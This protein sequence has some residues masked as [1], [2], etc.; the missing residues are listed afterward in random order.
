MDATVAYIGLLI[1][2]VSVIATLAFLLTRW[3]WFR[4]LL[5]N[6]SEFK[7]RL[8][9]VVLFG[10]IGIIGTY[11]GIVVNTGGTNQTAS[12]VVGMSSTEAI[13]NAR[14]L[15]VAIAGIL[16][17]P[18]M[19]L[20]SGLLAGLHR[21]A[22]GG[23]TDL[24]CAL[25]TIWEGLLAGLIA[26]YWFK[27]RQLSVWQVFIIGIMAEI[28]QMLI[29]LAV[30]KPYNMAL[31][32]VKIIGI[33][34][35]LANSIGLAVFFAILRSVTQREQEAVA[36]FAHNALE[37]AHQTLP[38]F[39]HGLTEDSARNTALIIQRM[40]RVTA[41][42]LT[43]TKMI[44]AF[45]GKGAD[46]HIAGTPLKTD[47]THSVIR[48]GKPYVAED[49]KIIGCSHQD[50]PL[51]AAI[52]L[53]LRQ[54]DELIGTL[55]LYFET[56][57]EIT[58]SQ[59]ELMTG[60]ANLFS[61]QLEL[62][63]IEEQQRLLIEAEIKAL[64]AQ[65]NPHFLFNALNTIVALIRK[66]PPLAR[67]IAIQL[68]QFLRR[69][70]YAGQQR[71]R[72]LGD[73]LDHIRDYLAIETVRFRDKLSVNYDIE[74]SALNTLMPPLI[75]LPLV[76]NAI[77]HGITPLNRPGEIDIRVVASESYVTISVTDDGVGME[78]T[79]FANMNLSDIYP[80]TGQ[81]NGFGIYS[82]IRRMTGIYGSSTSV[83]VKSK[84]QEGT[85]ITLVFPRK[86][87]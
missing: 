66:E 48:E 5:V 47:V 44:L 22:L 2:R 86:L 68:G 30:A 61:T 67:Q 82:V 73:E 78:N 38:H 37:I 40:T 83:S 29:I 54:R 23:F 10:L 8:L 57:A 81:G 12:S 79:Y 64:Q 36:N 1:E 32:L 58:P 6:K 72:T 21:Y 33:P 42:A 60:L 71:W 62:A 26:H 27:C 65:V 50:C 16:G 75:L 9:F 69:N 85:V 11:T 49:K 17:G 28:S 53:P 20:A 51:R 74:E 55:K 77:K 19:G 87:P 43:D 63:R 4:E 59:I 14:M 39:R 70:I 34:M 46:H 25:A 3:T 13:I 52:V 56:P 41:V 15:G 31:L 76:E 84:N 18:S 35:I 45:V 7:A 80:S 24:A